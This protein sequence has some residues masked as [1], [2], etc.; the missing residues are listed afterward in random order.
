MNEEIEKQKN[1]AKKVK[2]IFHKEHKYFLYTFG[3]Q[4]NENDSEKIAGMLLDMGYVKAENVGESDLIVFNT[5]CV[6]EHAEDKVYGYLGALKQLHSEKPEMVIAVCGCMAQQK[7]VQDAIKK[8]Y[9]HV[10]IVLGTHNLYKFPELLLDVLETRKN[11]IEVWESPGSVIEGIPIERESDLKAWVTIMYGCDN[12]CT[13]CIVPHVRGFERSRSPSDIIIEIEGLAAKGIKE[14]N[15]L[16]Q[17]VNSYKGEESGKVVLF[18]DLLKKINNIGGLERIRFMTSHPK[19][20]SHD[21]IT[22]MRDSEKVCKHLHLPVQS[23]S[24]RILEKMNRKYTKE[25]YLN[26]IEKIKSEIPDITLSTD[27]IVGFPG[28]TEEDFED[29]LD[30][31]GKV[32]F[33]SAFT[34]LYS[35]RTGTPAAS[36]ENQIT[37]KTAKERFNRLLELQTKIGREKNELMR[38]KHVKVLCEGKS[39]NNPDMLTGRTDGNKTVNFP[40]GSVLYGKMLMV[41]IVG[42]RTWSLEGKVILVLK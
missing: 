25:Y 38:G 16:G 32:R 6:R 2:E 40:G 33:D 7:E 4:M 18:P 12:F 15:L 27:I 34:F 3:C 11:I 10:D 14:I 26:L 39:K 21:L 5:C 22:A 13:Y 35:K 24:S 23:G 29:T 19:D 30:V 31:I 17:N 37:E 1:Y 36:Y 28:E 41:E 8:K 42:V 20:L 9:R